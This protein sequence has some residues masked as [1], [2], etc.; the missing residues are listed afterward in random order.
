MSNLV[1]EYA[2]V[3]PMAHVS[4]SHVHSG[5]RIWQF[6]SVI[7]GAVVLEGAQIAHG[8]L[9][10][11]AHVGEGALIGAGALVHP[12]TIIEDYVFV[13]PGVTF[14]ND[15][16][17]RTDKSGFQLFVPALAM[18]YEVR[19]KEATIVVEK[20][21]SIGAN[22]TILPGVV[23]GEGCMIAAGAVVRQS[24]GPRHLLHR[25]GRVSPIP[26]EQE[27]TGRETRV[28]KA[29]RRDDTL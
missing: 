22:A 27:T 23:L 8:A 5:V 18:H 19:R 25:S 24:V 3:H 16:W 20:G 4:D 10:D 21:A 13:G 9:V 12:G 28:R 29:L 1:S 6:A 15:A 26:D 2:L 7:R 17:P 11:G 14:C